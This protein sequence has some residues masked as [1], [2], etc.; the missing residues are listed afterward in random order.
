RIAVTR[1]A[2][3]MLLV[4]ASHL[5]RRGRPW[6]R[7]VYFPKGEVL[8]AYTTPDKRVLLRAD[9]IGAIVGGIRHELLVRA[10]TRP[11]FQRAVIDR[12]LVDLPV[13]L[14]ERTASPAK[15]AWPRGSELAI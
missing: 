12:A 2:P 3:A 6:Q 14:G 15:I 4:L 13:P 5:A 10:E 9:A 1:G 7:R 8:R 11:K